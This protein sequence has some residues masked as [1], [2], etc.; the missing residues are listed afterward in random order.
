MNFIV[1]AVIW[2]LLLGAIAYAVW[3][4]RDDL[5][6]IRSSAESKGWDHISIK[7]T[8]SPH[9]NLKRGASYYEVKF[10]DQG[11]KW[12]EIYCKVTWLAEV[13]W[14]NGY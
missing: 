8:I 12:H 3:V 10:R 2:L 9:L 11:G 6:R 7:P 1:H 13:V 4:P 14:Q 5:R